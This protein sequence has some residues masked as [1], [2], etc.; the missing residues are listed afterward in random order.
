MLCEA[1]ELPAIG[2][3]LMSW[4]PA[5]EAG[6]RAPD[7]LTASSEF[8][9]QSMWPLFWRTRPLGGCVKEN[10]HLRGLRPL[11]MLDEWNSDRLAA[12]RISCNSSLRL[13]HLAEIPKLED[14]NLAGTKHS[15]EPEIE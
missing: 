8:G 6:R 5:V 14:A 12:C 2:S 10:S 4:K 13:Q 11:S 7:E 1:M 3:L 15:E 9:A